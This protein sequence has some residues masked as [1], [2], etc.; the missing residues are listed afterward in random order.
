MKTMMTRMMVEIF[1][2]ALKFKYDFCLAKNNS[3]LDD[4]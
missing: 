1:L 2:H 4:C 3:C